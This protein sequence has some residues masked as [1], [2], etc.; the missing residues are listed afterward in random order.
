MKQRMNHFVRPHPQALCRRAFT[1]IELLIVIGLTAVLFALLLYP[2]VSAIRYTKQAQ[3]VTAAQDAVRITREMLTRELGSAMFVFDGTS[4]PFLVPGSTPPQPGDDRYTNFL[5]LQIQNSA[6]NA[7]V[8]HAYSA[9]LDFVLPRTNVGVTDPTTGEQITYRPAANGS[10]IVSNPAYVFP[11]ASGTTMIRYWIGLRDPSQPYTNIYEDYNRSAA[12]NT[13]ILYRAQF[14]P[15]VK[16]GT[17]NL[18]INTDLFAARSTVDANGNKVT[19]PDMDDPD[20]FRYVNLNGATDVNWLDDTH[21]SYPTQTNPATVTTA[22]ADGMADQHNY[23]VEKWMQI[24]KPVIPGQ[25]LD[26]ILLPHNADNTLAYDTGT[27]GTPCSASG[28]PGVAHSGL[29]HDPVAGGYYPIINTSVTFR[30]ATVSGDAV[31]GTTSDYG[32]QG[33]PTVAGESGYIYVPTVYTATSRSWALP[34]HVSLYPGNYGGSQ[35]YYATQVSSLTDTADPQPLYTAGDLLEYSYAGSTDTTGTLVYNVT[36]GYPIVANGAGGYKLGGTDFVPFSV[37]P[38]TGTLN[39]ASP[40]FPAGPTGLNR[41]QN[42]WNYAYDATADTDTTGGVDPSGLI[43][44]TKPGQA[45]NPPPLTNALLPVA[46]APNVRN[47]H[48]VP[49]GI[50]VTG[51]DTTPGPNQYLIVP[52]TEVSTSQATIPGENQYIVDYSKN[53]IQISPDMAAHLNTS[54]QQIGVVYNYQSNMTLTDPTKGFDAV[55][56]PYLPMQ[57]KLDYQTR[58]L[59]DVSIGVRLYDISTYRAQVI[60]SETKIK[61]GNSNPD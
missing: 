30:P 2:L 50:R 5:D 35:E 12:S 13:Y 38:D 59:I 55:T 34:F 7:V 10:A 49:G 20:F 61:I 56:N 39:F 22:T 4:H 47:A 28:C 21:A 44:L 51:P 57:V 14:Q 54:G 11:L 27:A 52:Y 33:L 24:A 8:G 17:G 1:L 45:A 9:K 16:N 29:A 15:Y 42:N 58:D 26:L 53:T 41:N 40:S 60:P 36:K 43:D 18:T 37:N 31:P 25:N 48:L 23:R 46:S 3:I 32:A 6:G 19:V